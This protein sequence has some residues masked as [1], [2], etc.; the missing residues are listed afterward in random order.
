[1][2]TNQTDNNVKDDRQKSVYEIQVAGLTLK[3]R[4][5]HDEETVKQLAAL[6]DTK[7]NEA[8]GIGKN[9]SFQNA[10]LLAA[11]HLAEDL[12][13]VR[14]LAAKDLN[15][16]EIKAQDILSALEASPLSR[17]RIDS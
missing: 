13:L 10:I 15:S 16:L 6:V 3:L 14:K 1:M 8:M 5:Y 4:S 17:I 7:I 2:L 12:T 9:I 11:L